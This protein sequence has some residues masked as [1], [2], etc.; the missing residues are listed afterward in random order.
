MAVELAD[1]AFVFDAIEA[2]QGA[3]RL[4]ALCEREQTTLLVDK[5]SSWVTAMLAQD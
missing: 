5:P 2:A 3:H 1:A 4:V